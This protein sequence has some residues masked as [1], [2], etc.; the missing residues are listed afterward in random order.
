MQ[1]NDYEKIRE[2]TGAMLSRLNKENVNSSGRKAGSRDGGRRSGSRRKNSRS[3]SRSR[4]RSRRNRNK[5]SM[6]SCCL[7]RGLNQVFIKG[8]LINVRQMVMAA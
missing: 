7:D 8:L 5:R 6:F 2:E 3:R 4:E 1:P